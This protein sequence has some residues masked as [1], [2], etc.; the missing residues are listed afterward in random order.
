MPYDPHTA[1]LGAF[2]FKVDKYVMRTEKAPRE[3]ANGLKLI[4]RFHRVLI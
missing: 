4:H 3:A 1:F 2:L